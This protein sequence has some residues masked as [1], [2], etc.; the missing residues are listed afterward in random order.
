M[1][2]FIQVEGEKSPQWENYQYMVNRNPRNENS[3]SI[4]RCTGG[5]NWKVEGEVSYAVKGNELEIQVPKR[6]LKIGSDYILNFKWT[7]NVPLDGN[8]MH[9]LD[10]GD[11]A[12]NARFNYQFIYGK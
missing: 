1:N 9:F 7:D 8:P 3:T 4:E 11:A 12:P 5:W 6:I 2:L 10:K